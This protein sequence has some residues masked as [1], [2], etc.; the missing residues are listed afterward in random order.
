[1][2]PLVVA[3]EQQAAEAGVTMY[4]VLRSAGISHSVWSRW[5]RGVVAP[6]IVTA[7]RIEAA[8]ADYIR[9]KTAA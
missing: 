2:D 8:L 6:N 9:G 5:R 7:R 1:M 4:A 3:I